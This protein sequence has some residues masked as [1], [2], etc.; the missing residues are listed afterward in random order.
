MKSFLEHKNS[1][2][3]EFTLSDRNHEIC[4]C[5]Y[6]DAS[7]LLSSGIVALVPSEDLSQPQADQRHKPLEFL[8]VHFTGA[9][10]GWS[11]LEIKSFAIMATIQRIHWILATS[12]GFDHLRTTRI[13]FF[14]RPTDRCS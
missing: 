7:D 2:E 1:L 12:D 9:Q 6:T 13:L 14:I 8:S 3:H 10:L 11:P 5:V 4:L